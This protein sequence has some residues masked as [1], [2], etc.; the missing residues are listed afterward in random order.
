MQRVMLPAFILIG[1][2]L[3]G[4]GANLLMPFQIPVIATF[5]FL[6]SASGGVYT[7]FSGVAYLLLS[8][9]VFVVSSILYFLVIRFAARIDVSK[10]GSYEPHPECVPKM[11]SVKKIGLTLVVVLFLLL[12]L[13]SFIPKS[14]AI[15]SLFNKFGIV[16]PCMLVIGIAC[17]II[18]KD[19]S[20]FVRFQQLADGIGWGMIFM[21][22]TA[23][24][25]SGALNREETGIIAFFSSILTPIFENINPMIFVAVFLLIGLVATNVL[26]NSVVS[27]VMIPVGYT[28]CSMFDVNPLALAAMFTI[29]ATYDVLL[30]LLLHKLPL[31]LFF[32]SL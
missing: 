6:F 29:I 14:T 12:L 10:L 7:S 24:A 8:S 27:A 19:G 1:V 17:V 30:M 26:N 3:I 25:M 32:L 15:G 16:G 23:T 13:P 5:G 4:T 18:F 28:L 2:V 22:G 31:D 21:F 20:L 9:A 11:G